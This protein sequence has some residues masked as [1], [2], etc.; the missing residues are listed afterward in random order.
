MQ[1]EKG[2][3]GGQRKS[4]WHQSS[5]EKLTFAR[6]SYAK[7]TNCRCLICYNLNDVLSQSVDEKKLKARQEEANKYHLNSFIKLVDKQEYKDFV[8]EKHNQP[9]LQQ[10]RKKD[11]RKQLVQL[12]F[13]TSMSHVTVTTKESTKTKRRKERKN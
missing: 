11:S 6:N 8:S 2:S 5:M 12:L 10:R 7:K 1:V 13:Q 3:Y 9:L 4:S